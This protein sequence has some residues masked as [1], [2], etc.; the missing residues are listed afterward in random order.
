MS[1]LLQALDYRNTNSLWGSVLVETVHRL[2]LREVVIS[3]GSR[4]TPLTMAFTRHAGIEAIP[5][6]DERSAAF[7]AI[8]LARQRHRPVALLCTSGTAG[9]NYFPAI[10]EAQESGVPLLVITA[11]RPPEMR[12]CRSGQTIDQQKLFGSH[13]NH[14]HELA[15]P[16][17]SLPMLRYLRQTV[18]HAWERSQWPVS[19]PVHLNAPFRDPLPPVEDGLTGSVRAELDE[20]GFFSAIRSRPG[21]RSQITESIRLGGRGIIVAG[22]V[23]TSDPAAYAHAVGRL[24]TRLGWPVL[25]DALSPLRHQ[26][27]LVPNLVVT[28]DLIARSGELMKELQP[29]HVLCL[30]DWP[31]S[32]ALRQWLQAGDFATI[33]VRRD[34]QNPDALHGR[35]TLVRASVEALA[36]AVRPGPKVRGWID[37]WLKTDR[38]LARGLT[39]GLAATEEL[40]EGQAS[41]LLP[42]LLPKGTPLFVANSMPVRDLEYFCPANSR[43]LA[44]HCNRGAN[45]IDGT[46]STAL[47][48]AHGSQP[49]VL[50]TGDL[51]LLHD[52][53]GFLSV[54]KFKGSLTIVLINNEG[55]GIFGHLPVARFDPPF[56]EFFATPQQVDFAT[57]CAA[58]GVKHERVRDWKHFGRLLGVLP[59]RGVRVLEVHTDRTRDAATRK[60]L[61]ARLA[62]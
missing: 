37:A 57:L 45:G 17:A 50:L 24:A 61:F 38:R 39:R 47:G 10:I 33:F 14:Y 27:R 18:A 8:G 23:R 29:Q 35:T 28:Y 55:G 41:A 34:G 11:D 36:S 51:A 1:R 4:S 5:V 12:E 56:E 31:T 54:P 6:L 7:F 22:Q 48:L 42:G 16:Q 43:G 15:V 2:G 52:A 26:A 53:N 46:L 62:G 13:V 19:G 25:A 20:R 40:F 60:E 21:Q 59:K 3:P 44:V 49:S 58:H 30:H 9:A 32:K